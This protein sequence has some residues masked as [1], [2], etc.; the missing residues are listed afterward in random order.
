MPAVVI[1]GAQWGDE[2]KG[3]VVDLLSQQADLVVRFQGGNNAGHT[4]VVNG[5]KTVLHLVPSGVL[6]PD[7]RC[8][9]ASGVV[10]DPEVLSKELTLL[11]ER[12]LLQ[13]KE[14]LR[15]SENAA[16]ILPYHRALDAA[17]EG[18]RK[19]KIG[20]TGRG[21]GPTYEDV[22]SRRSIP[23]RT[24]LDSNELR[25]RVAK[26]LPEKNAILSYYGADTFT[27]DEI[28]EYALRHA[29]QIAPHISETGNLVDSA[30]ATGQKVLFEGA[31]GALLDVLHGTVPYVTSS[32]TIGAA[33]CTGTGIGAHRLDKVLGIA[34]AYV[35]R[36]GG[37]PLP[38]LIGGAQEEKLRQLGGEYGATTGRPRRCGWLDLPS[39]QYAVRISGITELALTKLDVLSG[40]GDLKVC[41]AYRL[42]GQRLPAGVLPP[43]ADLRRVE[44]EYITAAG[45][46]EDI[47]MVRE[48]SELPATAQQYLAF[49]EKELGIPITLLSVGAD[50]DATLIREPIF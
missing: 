11:A 40:L 16:L 27:V 41:T 45:W 39:L 42:D 44:A 5:E 32:H 1:A 37:G 9:I 47:S 33:A 28:V 24:I 23:V 25:E 29:A 35:T 20:T 2:G 46:K 10:I 38:T 22:A 36:V 21:I 12:D 14:R 8:V 17:R 48:E 49:I 7:T 6:Q 34:K 50:R 43:V 3:K 15:I 18:A 30:L 26:V 4:L 31:Q 13:N 19:A